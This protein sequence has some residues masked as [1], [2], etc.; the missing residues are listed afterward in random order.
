MK[1]FVLGNIRE[2]PL[3][4]LSEHDPVMSGVVGPVQT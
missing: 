2:T 4:I 3:V 1:N